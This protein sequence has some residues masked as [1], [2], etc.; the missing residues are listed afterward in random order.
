MPVTVKNKSCDQPDLLAGF[1]HMLLE[2][3]YKRCVQWTSGQGYLCGILALVHSFNDQICRPLGLELSTVEDVKAMLCSGPYFNLAR[4]H[5]P[6]QYYDNHKYVLKRR[7]DLEFS[8]VALLA[9]MMGRKRGVR[10]ELVIC[11]AAYPGAAAHELCAESNYLAEYPAFARQCVY[12]HHN[13]ARY[14]PDEDIIEIGH[15]SAITERPLSSTRTTEPLKTILRQPQGLKLRRDQLCEAA[16]GSPT[17][18]VQVFTDA[19]E[20]ILLT[21]FQK[22]LNGTS[23]SDPR[24]I[25]IP[26]L[27]NSTTSRP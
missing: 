21:A 18:E 15:Y 2:T 8:Q 5:K 14:K 11:R 22:L 13:G 25:Q 4:N 7:N 20:N 19:A 3:M 6:S 23:D 17:D 12:I 16:G 27:S 10:V 1:N 9:E 26:S 24:R